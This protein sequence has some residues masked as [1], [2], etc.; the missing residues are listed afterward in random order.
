MKSI[1][2]VR[3]I[4][5]PLKLRIVSNGIVTPEIFVEIPDSSFIRC[6]ASVAESVDVE[7]PSDVQSTL[8]NM[9]NYL[10]A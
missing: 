8:P 2:V 3:N 1:A 9:F 7:N 6:I 5:V 10:Y 4:D